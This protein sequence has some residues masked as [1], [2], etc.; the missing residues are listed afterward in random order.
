MLAVALLAVLLNRDANPLRALVLAAMLVL[1]VQPSALLEAGFQLSFAAA[2][3][4]ILAYGRLR[5]W[6]EES[7]WQIK[8]WWQKALGYFCGIAF[9]TVI[10]TLATAPLVIIHFQQFVTLGLI[11]NMLALPILS[12][13]IAP[14]MILAALLLPFGLEIFGLSIASFGIDT[15][16]DVAQSVTA[17]EFAA[18][19]IPMIPSWAQWIILLLLLTAMVFRNIPWRVAAVSASVMLLAS[20][21][22]STPPDILISQDAQAV[23]VRQ[24]KGYALLKGT[25]RHFAV[26]N[27]QETLGADFAE[28]DMFSCDVAG[29]V[30]E[31]E[32][33]R[34]AMPKYGRAA[35][36]DCYQAAL[37]ITKT[38]K[39]PSFCLEKLVSLRDSEKRGGQVIWFTANG[40]R[41]WQSCKEGGS[42]PWQK[43]PAY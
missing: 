4:L 30:F 21:M 22:F 37:L 7:I 25:P 36:A 3:A 16:L 12:F 40:I 39:V 17:Y 38:T 23:A 26:E 10:A 28:Y 15:V 31:V 29:C 43:C 6:Q 34:I 24:N 42:R 41:H 5:K 9:S 32:N 35:L 13:L 27:W 33:L 1:L 20:G 2:F 14:G 19:H 18:L 11:S 8:P